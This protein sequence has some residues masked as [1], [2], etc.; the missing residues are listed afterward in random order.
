MRLLILS[1]NHGDVQALKT[2]LNRHKDVDA[3]LHLGDIT[4][5]DDAIS[6]Y[7]LI[8]VKGNNYNEPESWPDERTLTFDDHVIFMTHG[9][10]Y[11]VKNG[12]DL[13]HKKAKSEKAT[14]VLYGH[15]HQLAYFSFD[16]IYY[17]NPGSLHF[18]SSY[19]VY[20][21][22]IITFYDLKGRVIH[23]TNH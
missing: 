12:I 13:L 20:D 4:L 1:D 10:L 14:L 6:A 2:A 16:G 15:T 8:G 17:V 3:V 22:G 19:C 11:A 7:P 21:Q 5:N 18:T 23:G 9:H